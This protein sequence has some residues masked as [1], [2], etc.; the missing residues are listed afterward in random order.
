MLGVPVLVLGGTPDKHSV[1]EE[2]HT[3][4]VNAHGALLTLAMKVV[5]EQQL[6][7]R[8]MKSKE[9]QACRVAYLGPTVSG[10]TQVGVEFTSPA[11]HFWHIAFPPEDWSPRSPGSRIGR[12][13]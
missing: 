2:T 11:P 6:T 12:S 4:V 5:P 9:E 13:K 7:I 3:L 10:K 8:N 1:L